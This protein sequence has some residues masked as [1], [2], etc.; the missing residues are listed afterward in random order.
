VQ[1][2][3]S[4]HGHFAVPETETRKLVHMWI[5]LSNYSTDNMEI[6]VIL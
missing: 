5:Y 3:P 6:R 2:E 4:A 1:V